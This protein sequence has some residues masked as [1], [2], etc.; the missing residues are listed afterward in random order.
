MSRVLL[1]SDLSP[2]WA[3]LFA[4]VHT[5]RALLAEHGL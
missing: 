4:T 5:N 1:Y 3:W 2:S